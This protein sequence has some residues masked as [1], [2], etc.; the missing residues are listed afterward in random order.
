[1]VL[2]HS[3]NRLISYFH[4]FLAHHHR[5]SSANVAT[6]TAN[7]QNQQDKKKKKCAHPLQVHFALLSLL[8]PSTSHAFLVLTPACRAHWTHT[9]RHINIYGFP[10][11]MYDEERRTP[12]T[13]PHFALPLKWEKE[14]LWAP[15]EAPCRKRFSKNQ[16]PFPNPFLTLPLCLFSGVESLQI[17]VGRKQLYAHTHAFA[18][19]YLAVMGHPTAAVK[20]F[21][22]R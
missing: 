6:L 1:M 7:P 16:L 22:N 10:V 12:S 19:L 3:S 13:L 18:R 9:H 4:P 20:N 17:L 8:P 14:L 11:C 21:H 15:I 2:S 5:S